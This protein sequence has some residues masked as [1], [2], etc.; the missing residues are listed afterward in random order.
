MRP[1]AA[2]SP[3]PVP[4]LAS[5][6]KEPASELEEKEDDLRQSGKLLVWIAVVV[7]VL[8]GI[9]LQ[10]IVAVAVVFGC[11]G[12]LAFLCFMLSR[13]IGLHASVVAM[14]QDLRRLADRREK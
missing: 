3:A 7:A 4:A 13:L 11:V 9:F 14:R 12:L 6:I 5:D 10:N 8:V 2:P 1:K